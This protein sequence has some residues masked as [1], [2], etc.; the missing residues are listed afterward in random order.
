MSAIELSRPAAF[1]RRHD[2]QLPKTQMAP[3][4][5]PEGRPSS[6]EDVGDL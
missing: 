3:P 5:L 6:T 4:G 2:L 1:D